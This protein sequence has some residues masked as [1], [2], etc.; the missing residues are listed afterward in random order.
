M[1]ENL[2]TELKIPSNATLL[3]HSKTQA[4]SL[5]TSSSGSLS[6]IPLSPSTSISKSTKFLLIGRQASTAD[7]RINHKSISRKH[8]VLY[9]RCVNGSSSTS[10]GDSTSI[11]TSSKLELVLKDLGGKFGCTINGK[12]LERETEIILKHGDHVIFGNVREQAF[13]I[14]FPDDVE[15]LSETSTSINEKVQPSAE[16]DKK[17]DAQKDDNVITS[18]EM[19]EMSLTGRA[20]REAEIA[21]MTASLDETPVYTKFKQAVAVEAITAT[22]TNSATK[23]HEHES[24]PTNKENKQDQDHDQITKLKIPITNHITIPSASSSTSSCLLPTTISIDPSGSRLLVGTNNGTIRLYD[25]NGMDLSLQPFKTLTIQEGRYTI[26]SSTFSNSGDRIILGTTSSQPIVLD[27]DGNQIIEFAKGDMY[28]TDMVHTDGHVANVTSVDWHPFDRDLV[29]SGSADGSV[30]VWDLIRCKTKFDKLCCGKLIYRVK[31]SMGKRTKISTVCYSPNGREFTCGTICGSIQIWN[32]TKLKSRPDKVIYD[33]HDGKNIAIH[34]IVYNREGTQIASRCMEDD[35]V[36]VWVTRTLSRS[37]KPFMICHG[38]KSQYEYSNSSFSQDGKFIC[39]GTSIDKSKS[40]NL[41]NKQD[42]GQLKIFKIESN[43]NGNTRT[44]PIITV[45]IALGINVVTSLWHKR[46]NQIFLGLSD[47][48]IRIYYHPECSTKGA[49]IPVSKG[50]RKIDELSLLLASRAPTGSAGIS[51]DSIQTPHAL[52]LFRDPERNTK[53]KRTKE[54]Q[55]PIKSKRPDLPGTGIKVGESSSAGLNFQQYN[56]TSAIHKN[57]NIA[58][59]DPRD[60]LFKFNEGKSYTKVPYDGDIKILAEKT[61][62]EEEQE[63][64]EKQN[65]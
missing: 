47:G 14:I 13:Q 53:R 11:N 46:L 19:E 3:V 40:S 49:L 65:R 8:A 35:K 33:A 38:L 20:A 43:T 39:A 6:S 56:L 10:A 30:R 64:E 7:V 52:P 17:L 23:S 42:Y 26:S 48:S 54:R 58:G 22:N 50:V 29:L 4:P 59:I 41:T 55:D 18:N 5:Q 60:E 57:K 62:E 16:K 24:H 31:S 36:K 34:S 9:I 27:R 28:V 44:D 63:E 15:L 2:E 32:A 45:N 21:A 37:A 25:F 1:I 51:M 61:V 12:K